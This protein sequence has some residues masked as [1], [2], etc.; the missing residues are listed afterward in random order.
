MRLLID[1]GNTRAKVAVADAEG[2]IEVVGEQVEL[3]KS[4]LA[5]VVATYGVEAAL[6]SSTRGDAAQWAM[7]LR[8]LGI[9]AVALD[10][11]T[12]LPIEIAYRTPETL[13]RDRVAAAVGAATRFADRN[14]LVIDFGT[15]ITI[16][17]VTA[18][19]E[20]LGGMI[21]PGMESRFRA[22][23]DYT[24]ALPLCEAT[25]AEISVAR[26]TREAIEQGV[27]NSV[28]FEIEGYIARFSAI[29]AD[30]CVIVTGGGAKYFVKRIK[31]AIFAEPNLV[32]C[33]LNQILDYNLAS[34]ATTKQ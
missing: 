25:D 31:N 14:C 17:L 26:T 2:N 20:F 7:Q 3:A 1:I 18:E 28:Q 11:A 12:P 27:M 34:N 13:G 4:A 19:G 21:S 33:G 15:A 16:D 22:L 6:I 30:L 8:E 10:A 32:F 5:E 23:H 9:E 24:Q 29:Y